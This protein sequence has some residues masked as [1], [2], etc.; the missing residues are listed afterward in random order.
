M[1]EFQ[2][3][4]PRGHRLMSLSEIIRLWNINNITI[5]PH[6]W[7][8]SVILDEGSSSSNEEEKTVSEQSHLNVFHE[9]R[10][11]TELLKPDETSK[12]DDAYEK[13]YSCDLC[14]SFSIKA[15][16]LTHKKT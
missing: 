13:S 12:D 11:S 8:E 2:K 14:D 16:L 10:E 4:S 7:C 15:N 5:P 1:S 6:N 3:S 9:S